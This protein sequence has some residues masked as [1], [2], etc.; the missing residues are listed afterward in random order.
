MASTITQKGQVTIPV[1][2]RVRLGLVPGNSVEFDLDPDGRV[3]LRKVGEGLPPSKLNALRGK[4]GKG[5]TTDQV[6]ALTR[7]DLRR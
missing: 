4:A 7:G 1:G 3:V 5:M 2:V 6:M